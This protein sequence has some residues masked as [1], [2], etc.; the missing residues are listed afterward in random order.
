MSGTLTFV[1]IPAT[2]LADLQPKRDYTMHVKAHFDFNP[3]D[4]TYPE[5]VRCPCTDLGLT[6]RKG[7]ILHVRNQED[8]WWQ[9]YR[10]GEE[11][12]S[13]LAGLI[14]SKTFQ[15]AREDHRLRKIGD[16][17]LINGNTTSSYNE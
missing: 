10:E 7:D 3:E 16:G 12:G 5:E 11:V 13:T 4:D 2:V 1:I 6:F 9:A 8:N 15:Q 17:T 14:P